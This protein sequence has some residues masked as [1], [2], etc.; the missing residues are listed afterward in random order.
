MSNTT[1]GTNTTREIQKSKVKCPNKFKIKIPNLDLCSI[2]SIWIQDLFNTY[3]YVL[4]VLDSIWT[5][6]SIGKHWDLYE[7]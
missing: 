7:T 1:N 6:V 5:L 3:W 4:V 2:C